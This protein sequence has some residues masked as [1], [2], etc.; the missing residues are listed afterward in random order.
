MPGS[1]HDDECGAYCTASVQTRMKPWRDTAAPSG[2]PV[3]IAPS[4]PQ[5]AALPPAPWW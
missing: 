4:L 2:S 1:G 5:S 3:V